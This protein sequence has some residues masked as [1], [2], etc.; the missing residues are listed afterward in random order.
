MAMGPLKFC[1]M[2]TP[3]TVVNSFKII[4]LHENWRGRG[5]LLLK[6]VQ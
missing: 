3:L 6:N 5:E 1:S 2:S 4:L